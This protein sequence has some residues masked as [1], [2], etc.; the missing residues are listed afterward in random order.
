MFPNIQP[1][2]SLTLPFAGKFK[3]QLKGLERCKNNFSLLLVCLLLLL[4]P[5]VSGCGA[6]VQQNEPD[7]GQTEDYATLTINN[8]GREVVIESMTESTDPGALY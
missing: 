2:V 1:P 6:K 5:A 3:S 8:Y 7:Q 4:V